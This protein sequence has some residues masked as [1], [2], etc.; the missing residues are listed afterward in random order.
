MP[1]SPRQ[2]AAP[3]PRLLEGIRI[4]DMTTVVFGPY[5]TQTLADL[6]A[7][8]P[9]LLRGLVCDAGSKPSH[10]SHGPVPHTECEAA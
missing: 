2:A 8:G 3:A 5:A 7:D 1:G 10:L 4:L 6:G 9:S